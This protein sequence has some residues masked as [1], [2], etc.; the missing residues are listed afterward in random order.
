MSR[1]RVSKS[2]E[3]RLEGPDCLGD[4]SWE[5]VEEAIDS[6]GVER[7]L[8]VLSLAQDD[9]SLRLLVAPVQ[10]GEELSSAEGPVGCRP[11]LL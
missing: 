8:P 10:L 6:G 11:G 2:A 4:R 1:S 9:G 3:H 7:R 5:I